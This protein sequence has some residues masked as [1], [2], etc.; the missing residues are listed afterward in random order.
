MGGREREGQ[1]WMD[2]VR[3][4]RRKSKGGNEREI[5]WRE[6]SLNGESSF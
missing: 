5:K 1:K 2:G 3:K 4:G 6:G